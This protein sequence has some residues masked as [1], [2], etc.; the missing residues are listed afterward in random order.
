MSTG[1]Y[2]PVIGYVL[3]NYKTPSSYA[4][5]MKCFGLRFYYSRCAMF[6]WY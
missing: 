2:S 5:K 4:I 6:Q 1:Y 3:D